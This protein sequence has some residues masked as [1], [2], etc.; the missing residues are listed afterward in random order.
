MKH[1]M[2]DRG[3]IPE[4]VAD[5]PDAE[6]QETASKKRA[7]KPEQVAAKPSPKINRTSVAGIRIETNPVGVAQADSAE[8]KNVSEQIG[9]VPITDRKPATQLNVSQRR[10]RSFENL[11]KINEALLAYLDANGH[12]PK[13]YAVNAGGVPTLSWRVELLPFLGC[14]ALYDQFDFTRAWNMQPNKDLLQYIPDEYVSPERFDAKTNYLLPVS[15]GFIF[16]DN[17]GIRPSM[18][19]D[20]AENTIMLLEVNDQHAVHWTEPKDL[21]PASVMKIRP[22]LGKLRVDG[23]FALWANGF[24][25]LL[26]KSLTDM[27]LFQA[28]TY[29]KN[30]ALQAKDIHRTITVEQAEGDPEMEDR[31]SDQ[32]VAID[33]T[34]VRVPDKLQLPQ[35]IQEQ[36]IQR[37]PVP[38]SIQL[39]AAQSKL[40]VIFR[41]KLQDAK[42]ASEKNKL[43]SELLQVADGMEADPAG[44]Y[45]LQRA[46]LKLA[47]DAGDADVMIQAI[48]Q[49][50]V[51][52]EVD[53]FRENLKWIQ[54]FGEA[55]ASRDSSVVKG[56]GL[57]QRAVPVIFA[58]I[59][60]NEYM[61][62]SSVSRIANRFT[63][64]EP[65]DRVSRLFSRL[66][67]Q[68]GAAKRE[69]DHSVES[70][71]QFRINPENKVAGAAFGRFL[72]FIKGDWQT[73]LN[74][75]ADGKGGDLVEVAR[76]DLRG[77][78][79]TNEQVA[80]G[81]AWWDLSRRG[82][83][84]YQQGA[85]DRAVMWYSQAFDRLPESLDRIHVKNRLQEADDT[86]GRS[87]IALCM[88]L[89]E[90]VGIDLSASLTSIA[91]QGGQSSFR[92]NDDDD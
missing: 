53:S 1:A 31:L 28:L 67:T 47:I 36:S 3:T 90:E 84:A 86:D 81:D 49:R 72:C 29:E 79:Q 46:A 18:I 6:P 54:A 58:G 48:D 26:E 78:S 43:A 85:Q 91:A 16:G 80:I 69:Y 89:A 57:L 17:R 66:R 25:V 55:T 13:S 68:L 35:G 38:T 87:P 61:L 10:R 88:Q 71:H 63:S 22:Y 9:M 34:H 51:R 39:T 73:G 92:T 11:Q 40:R 15:S 42:T 70:L 82:S 14:Q 41:E 74:L 30:D 27:Q 65:D 76:L 8:T 21:Q 12:Y 77:A 60:E 23:T 45:A 4:H 50:V 33:P 2:R 7:A 24:P 19:D 32:I 62:A 83:G 20:G 37:E 52:F 59:R 5:E 64:S 56:D 44:A 75:I